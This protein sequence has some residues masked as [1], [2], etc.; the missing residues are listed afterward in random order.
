MRTDRHT[1]HDK[2][3]AA[4]VFVRFVDSARTEIHTLWQARPPLTPMGSPLSKARVPS[5][6]PVFDARGQEGTRWSKLAAA[7][8]R[9]AS[10][11]SRKRA[12]LGLSAAA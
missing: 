12:G 5:A 3:I 2:C 10:I 7:V 6:W 1:F 11:V 8:E 9:I 4:L